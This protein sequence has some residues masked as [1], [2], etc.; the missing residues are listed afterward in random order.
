M[1]AAYGN[2]ADWQAFALGDY[3]AD[4]ETYSLTSALWASTFRVKVAPREA[5][6]FRDAF[7]QRSYGVPDLTLQAG[8]IEL[9][10]VPVTV[11]MG[12]VER[13]YNIQR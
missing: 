1:L 7:A 8:T 9:R 13:T 12:A 2:T 6:R 3:N 11:T 4:T 10:A 5:A